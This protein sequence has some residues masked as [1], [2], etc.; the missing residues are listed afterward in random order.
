MESRR[1]VEGVRRGHQNFVH[2]CYCR[3]GDVV[4]DVWRVV[5]QKSGR[6][7]GRLIDAMLKIAQDAKDS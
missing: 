7:D 6:L 5:V 4:A 3:I 1:V 2:V